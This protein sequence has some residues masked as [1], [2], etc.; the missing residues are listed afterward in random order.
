MPNKSFSANKRRMSWGNSC[1]TSIAA[2]RGWTFS[3]TN[4]RTTSRIASSSSS[5]GVETAGVTTVLLQTDGLG[6]VYNGKVQDARVKKEQF[7]PK[8]VGRYAGGAPLT[9]SATDSAEAKRRARS[10]PGSGATD[11]TI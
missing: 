1:A 11:R 10:D 2:A 9:T 8:T 3:R 6:R 4:C 5:S 7:P